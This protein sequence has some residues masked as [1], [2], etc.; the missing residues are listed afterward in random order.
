MREV[1]CQIPASGRAG[2]DAY[3]AAHATEEYGY[4][5]TPYIDGLTQI[6]VVENAPD[7]LVVDV[8]YFYRDRSKND[9]GGGQGQGRECTGF[10]GRQFTF[11]QGKAG[12]VA[13]LKMTGQRRG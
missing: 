11:G 8:R 6:R 9:R 10:A 3:Y 12:G 4:C 5:P 2:N 7:R 1:R 13:V